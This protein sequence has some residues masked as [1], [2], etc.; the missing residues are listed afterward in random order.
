VENM[1]QHSDSGSHGE[2][3]TFKTKTPARP[4]CQCDMP[5]SEFHDDMEEEFINM[6]L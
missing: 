5:S 3:N 6:E 2:L 4:Y 1:F